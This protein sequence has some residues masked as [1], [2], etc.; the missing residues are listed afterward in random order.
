M[1]SI[2]F[3]CAE[4]SGELV[5]SISTDWSVIDYFKIPFAYSFECEWEY[6]VQSYAGNRLYKYPETR[7]VTQKA[8]YV[9]VTRLKSD[10]SIHEIKVCDEDKVEICRKNLHGE[11][12]IKYE[13]IINVTKSSVKAFVKFN[14]S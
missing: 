7:K 12:L 5:K 13:T 3:N 11:N 9:S 14:F 1:W 2:N 10:N 4:K 8:A 6:T